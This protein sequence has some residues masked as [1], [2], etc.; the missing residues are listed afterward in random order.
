MGLAAL[1]LPLGLT[2]CAS[3]RY[4]AYYEPSSF[5]SGGVAS[6]EPCHP[7]TILELRAPRDVRIEVALTPEGKSLRASVSLRVPK[8]VTVVFKSGTFTF[9]DPSSGVTRVHEA[10]R[11]GRNPYLADASAGPEPALKDAITGGFRSVTMVI[12]DFSP[13][14]VRVVL[15]PLS[16]DGERF[17][18]VPVE[19]E[20]H[21]DM[22]A[23]C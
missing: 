5:G 2:A 11:F 6:R 20:Y 21:R 1:L 9:E 13:R 23:G 19:F 15:P 18:V 8:D 16:I 17:V 14:R 4:G 7:A 10:A 22:P 12:E 3:T